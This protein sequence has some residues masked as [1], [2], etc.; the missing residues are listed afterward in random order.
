MA[1]IAQIASNQS[2][3]LWKF[4]TPNGRSMELGMSFIFPLYR[5]RAN[6]LWKPD[7]MYWEEWPVRHPSLVVCRNQTGQEGLFASMEKFEAD[8]KT[9]EVLRNLPLRHPLLWELPN[10]I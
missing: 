1:G 7:V 5:T 2:E 3:D 4:T 9:F 6:G 10:G 8:P